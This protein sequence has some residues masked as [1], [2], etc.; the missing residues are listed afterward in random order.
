MSPLQRSLQAA[1]A[2]SAPPSFDA[3]SLLT[4]PGQSNPW[5]TNNLSKGF[6]NLTYA[7]WVTQ[8]GLSQAQ[9]KTIQ[10]NLEKTE[11]WWSQQPAGAVDTIRKV[12]IMM[13]I[14]L[15]QQPG[16]SADRGDHHD[17]LTSSHA[18]SKAQAQSPSTTPPIDPFDDSGPVLLDSI[19]HGQHSF[20]LLRF[21]GCT[22]PIDAFIKCPWLETQC[23]I[24]GDFGRRC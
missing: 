19:Y 10:V 6:A 21:P 1:A 8:L 16:Q 9:K 2:P 3:A 23:K 22:N 12:A 17:L 20:P 7:N 13:G 15:P 4:I 14:P 11:S 24:E 5:L 18:M